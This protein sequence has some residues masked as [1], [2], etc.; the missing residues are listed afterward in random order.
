MNSTQ[1][2]FN[3]QSQHSSN[4]QV[5]RSLDVFKLGLMMMESAIG[6]L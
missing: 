5:D 3:R 4:I 2:N 1:K 6:R